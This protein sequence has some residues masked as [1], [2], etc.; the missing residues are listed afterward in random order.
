VLSWTHADMQADP[1]DVLAAFERF[2]VRLDMS[3]CFL[4]GRR[5]GRSFL[6]SIFTFGMS[7]LSSIALGQALFDINAQPKMFHRE[8][9]KRMSHPPADFSLDLYAL[10]I[11]R[12]SGC[13]I[14]DQPVRFGRRQHGA[15]KGGGTLKG[16]LNLIRRTWSYIHRL[17][18]DLKE[19]EP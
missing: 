6:D 16:K 15:A 10:Y 17:R 3:S 1:A 4:K 11:A 14:L 7:M 9:L 5:I 18:R 8:F 2:T 13:V 19:Y 12:S